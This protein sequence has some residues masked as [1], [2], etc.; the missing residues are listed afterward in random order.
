LIWFNPEE[1]LIDNRASLVSLAG[2]AAKHSCF[3]GYCISVQKQNYH[4]NK[5]IGMT[6]KNSAGAGILAQ[7][8]SKLS[9]LR[10]KL[11]RRQFKLMLIDAFQPYAALDAEILK[12]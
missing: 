8:H 7:Q 9:G 12:R 2:N 6:A 1:P 10:H 5:M 4:R 3:Q 11:C